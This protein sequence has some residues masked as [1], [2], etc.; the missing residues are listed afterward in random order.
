[1]P[2]PELSDNVETTHSDHLAPETP[3][4]YN[5]EAET[6]HESMQSNT[7]TYEK[8]RENHR[9]MDRFRKVQTEGTYPNLKKEPP[10][11]PPSYSLSAPAEDV[12][13][14]VRINQYGVTFNN[15]LYQKNIV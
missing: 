13:K 15:N 14:R 8:L 9:N 5:P 11:S 3:S 4:M 1:M 7:M 2:Q 10:P 12:P 6:S